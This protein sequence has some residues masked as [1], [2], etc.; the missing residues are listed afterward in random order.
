M[1]YLLWNSFFLTDKGK[2]EK[3]LVIERIWGMPEHS[4][5]GSYLQRSRKEVLRGKGIEV[6]CISIMAVATKVIHLSNSKN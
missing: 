4:G 5:V 1:R 2:K 3:Y 6:F